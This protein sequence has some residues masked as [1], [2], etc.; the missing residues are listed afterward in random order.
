[1]APKEAMLI[2]LTPTQR[3]IHEL[4]VKKL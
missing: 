4:S 3:T 2:I 1:M